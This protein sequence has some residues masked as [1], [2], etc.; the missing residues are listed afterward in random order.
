MQL[1]LSYFK[2]MMQETARLT[3][4]TADGT[5]TFCI[6]PLY[7]VF[8]M[9]AKAPLLN[10][11]QFNGRCGCPVCLHPGIRIEHTQTYPPGT[12]YLIRTTESM[13]SDGRRAERDK[14]IVN[15]I[16]GTT[17]LSPLVDLASGCPIDYMHCVLEGVVKRL[18]EKWVTSPR[19]YY[20]LNKHS[21]EKID[22]SLTLQ[23]PP[24]DFTRAPR[25]LQKHRKFWKASEF[26]AWVLFY[27]LPLL[28]NLLPS[29]YIHHF[30]LLVCA[31]HILLQPELSPTQ[32]A[33]A[34]NMLRD[35]VILL[36][37]LYNA[38][39]CT[40]NAHLLLHLGQHAALWGPL[41]NF[42]AF[43]FEHKNGYLM[44]HIH[45]PH[46]IA[47]QLL[48]SL[49]LNQTLDTVQEDLLAIESENVLSFLNTPSKSKPGYVLFPDCYVIG[50]MYSSTTEGEIRSQIE[51][52][53]RGDCP[54][55]IRSFS[56]IYY[57]GTI[58]HST[59]YGRSDSKRNST[60]CSF[61]CNGKEQYGSIEQ[62]SI[63]NSLP[64][65]IIRPFI[66]DGSYLQ[67]AGVPGRSI[68][69]QYASLDILG[70]FI[71]QVKSDQTLPLI[72]VS[73][74]SIIHKCI[75]IHPV[76]S[77]YSFIVKIPNHYEYH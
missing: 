54:R 47:E 44:G 59:K 50:N 29:L 9:V 32:I 60:I 22:T 39:E 72:V 66:P 69:Q 36:P 71:I 30:A 56:Q 77:K 63:V 38:K 8:D 62:F 61:A 13:K 21:I 4:R 41:W 2:K 24:H 18:L 74:Q 65:A 7:G 73:V 5:K 14:I 40:F 28:L 42:S 34:E 27:S 46:R 10:M 31:L 3:V 49:D 12:D 48:F 64:I 70:A 19:T 76:S 1:F 58:L 23:R 11:N 45:S 26:R 33:T 57:Q 55:D 6:K 16:K 53:T 52:L 35:F 67:T 43:G 75:I 37:E 15:G 17:I 68:L 51:V 25:S 20:Y